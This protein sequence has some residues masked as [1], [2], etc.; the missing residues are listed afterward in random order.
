LINVPPIQADEALIRG[1]HPDQWNPNTDRPTSAAYRKTELSV[2]RERLRGVD[3]CCKMHP[4]WGFTRFQVR[5]ALAL[6]LEVKADPKT[7]IPPPPGAPPTAEYNPAHALV[8]GRKKQMIKLRDVAV[9]LVRPGGFQGEPK[10]APT[11]PPLS[12]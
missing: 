11:P 8:I 12:K 3:T 10:T 4:T 6:A 2:D 9:T 1:I 5:A 7:G